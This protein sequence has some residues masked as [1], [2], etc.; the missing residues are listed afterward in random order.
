MTWSTIACT[1]GEATCR[2]LVEKSVPMLWP[3]TTTF[4]RGIPGIG[5]S[6]AGLRYSALTRRSN[7]AN[8]PS[9]CSPGMSSSQLYGRHAR[10]VPTL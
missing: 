6:L 10:L 7:S 8:E 4:L 1:S 3:M 5:G 9:C 2:A